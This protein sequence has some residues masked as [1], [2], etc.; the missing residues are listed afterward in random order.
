MALESQHLWIILANHFK[1]KQSYEQAFYNFEPSK[2]AQMSTK[3][4]DDLMEFLTL[5]IIVKV[6]KRLYHKHKVILK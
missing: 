1:K 2:I 3:D 6:R 5:F 4:I